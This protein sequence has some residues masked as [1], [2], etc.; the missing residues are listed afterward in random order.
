[1]PQRVIVVPHVSRKLGAIGLPR[2]LLVSVLARL[3]HELENNANRFRGQRVAGHEDR[4]FV[5]RL[6]VAAAH[7]LHDFA[8][9]VDDATASG[10]LFVLD[11]AYRTR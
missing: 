11:L 2:E 3:R 6:L 7:R 5:I 10:T 1:M 8:F 9:A 4:L